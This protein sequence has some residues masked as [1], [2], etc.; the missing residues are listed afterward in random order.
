MGCVCLRSIFKRR[1]FIILPKPCGALWL[2]KGLLKGVAQSRRWLTISRAGLIGSARRLIE[3][4][5]LLQKVKLLLSTRAIFRHVALLITRE[6]SSLT[7]KAGFIG[8]GVS[9]LDHGE[10]WSV[11]IHGNCLIVWMMLLISIAIRSG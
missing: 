6:A 2:I 10:H 8:F 5:K 4:A 1:G 11:Y 3:L 9:T 7:L